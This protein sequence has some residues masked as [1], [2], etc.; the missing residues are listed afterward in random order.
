MAISNFVSRCV[1]DESPVIYGDGSQTRDFTY[2]DDVVD[3]NRVLLDTDAADGEVINIGSTDTIDIKTLAEVVRDELAP[4]LELAFGE[5]SE[6]DAEHTH[7]DV[8]K[9]SELLG[10]EPTTSIREGVERFVAW[11]HENREWYEPLVRNS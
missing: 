11:Y 4:D 3:A 10:Y 1:N 8:S 2:I 9:A 6:A 5:C 7:A